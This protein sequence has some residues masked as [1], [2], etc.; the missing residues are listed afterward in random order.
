MI[1]AL[2]APLILSSH[3]HAY[4][5]DIIV[6]PVYQQ[7][8]NSSTT[9]LVAVAQSPDKPWAVVE[10]LPDCFSGIQNT[11]QK[12]NQPSIVT[13]N[14]SGTYR[15]VYQLGTKIRQDQ[16][17]YEWPI[18]SPFSDSVSRGEWEIMYP[19]QYGGV[20]PQKRYALC[21]I[22]EDKT[23][24]DVVSDVRGIPDGWEDYV[25]PA[26]KYLRDHPV[27]TSSAAG[28]DLLRPLLRSQNPYLSITAAKLLAEEQAPSAADVGTVLSI[29]DPKV[30]GSD[31]SV[32]LLREWS[33]PL[34]PTTAELLDRA[35]S[36]TSPTQLE[37]VSIGLAVALGLAANPAPY[38]IT[39]VQDSHSV[40]KPKHPVWPDVLPTTTYP[41]DIGGAIL[42]GKAIRQ[43]LN[44]LAPNGTQGNAVLSIADTM[45]RL[46]GATSI[47]EK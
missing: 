46:T 8:K 12:P 31:I 23:G 20:T 35:P 18:T 1:F 22:H 17:R 5:R 37:G 36:L 16:E 11:S 24:A 7:I 30:I 3:V 45:C 2:G 42:V 44:V 14:A 10:I 43:R 32:F 26:V 40:P 38:G 4:P 9:D 33:K 47:A 6:P 29:P 15:V 34:K 25:Q 41:D 27:V 39:G 28:P 13:W 19:F 21:Q